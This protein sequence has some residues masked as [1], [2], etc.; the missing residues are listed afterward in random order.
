MGDLKEG[1][2][3]EAEWLRAWIFVARFRRERAAVRW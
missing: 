1:P 2:V 3:S